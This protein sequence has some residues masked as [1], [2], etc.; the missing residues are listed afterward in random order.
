LQ[1]GTHLAIETLEDPNAVPGTGVNWFKVAAPILASIILIVSV[2]TSGGYLMQAVVDEKENRTMEL[3]ATSLSPQQIMSGKILAL[4]S[5]GLTQVLI[6][7]IFPLLVILLMGSYLPFLFGVA[8][9]WSLIGLIAATTLPTFVLV[10]ALMAT[11]GATV[12]EA[13]EGQ[14]VSALITL[15]VMAPYMLISV[16][17]ANPN[18]PIAIALTFFPLTS[19]ITLLMRVA[20]ATVPDWQIGLSTGLLLFWAI[21]SL[22]LAGRV[23]RAGMLRYGKRMGWSDVL[24][25]V[26]LRKAD[27]PVKVHIQ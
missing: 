11:V 15:P 24:E 5:V 1:E 9:D 12:T 18:G 19:A 6:W 27:Q 3:L 10:S 22:W 17:V 7:S 21:G 20:F 26:T 25:A 14:Q 4:L 23:F 13:R 16:I 2:F 8:I